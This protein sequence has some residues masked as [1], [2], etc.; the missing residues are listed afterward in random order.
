MTDIEKR[1]E[2]TDAWTRAS[3]EGRPCV[4]RRRLKTMEREPLLMTLLAG[5]DAASCTLFHGEVYSRRVTL[6]LLVTVHRRDALARGLL[7]LV[8]LLFT[9]SCF[10]VAVLPSP[11]SSL[12]FILDERRHRAAPLMAHAAR[13]ALQRCA[14]KVLWESFLLFN[15][16]TGC[17]HPSPRHPGSGTNGYG[18]WQS[19]AVAGLW[20]LVAA[21]PRLRSKGVF[22]VHR[23]PAVS[24]RGFS[25]SMCN[26]A[27]AAGCVVLA[28]LVACFPQPPVCRP[29]TRAAAA[30]I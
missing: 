12:T 4:E 1:R 16:M 22:G 24:P 17:S 18:T 23:F 10:P 3:L 15:L 14:T 30:Q 7:R 6:F 25:S 27:G 19:T 13:L 2:G 5:T 11:F 8:P 28:H 29:L 20:L 26:L 21:L 9:A